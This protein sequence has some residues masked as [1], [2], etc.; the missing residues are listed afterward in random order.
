MAYPKEKFDL[1]ADI[2]LSLGFIALSD[3]DTVNFTALG[4]ERTPTYSGAR[5]IS[6]AYKKIKSITP[7]GKHDL[8]REIGLS[9][10]KTKAP[11]K[12]FFISDFLMPPEELIQAL[13]I[14]LAKN[15]E[16][17]LINVLSPEELDLST[18]EDDALLV[19]SETGSDLQLSV[20]KETKKAY[21]RALAEHIDAIESFS[22]R[23]AAPYL[24]VSS[25]DSL[26][27]VVL[28]K[29]PKQGFIS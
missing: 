24:L 17:G 18:L 4:K 11:G 5:A 19:D 23:S 6:R 8:K 1:A 26:R 14:P 22:K 3:G 21:A 16:L 15:F 7:S 9:V 28:N 10:S 12:C 13:E 25:A 2:A 20:G 29:F 27:E